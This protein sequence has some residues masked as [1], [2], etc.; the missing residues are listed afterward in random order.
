[1]IS[2]FKV[3]ITGGRGFTGRFLS[4]HLQNVGFEVFVLKSNFLDFE[5]LNREV[6]SISPSYVIHLGALSFAAESNV[7]KLYEVNVVGTT[8]LLDSLCNLTTPLTKIILASSAT[9]YGNLSESYLSENMIPKPV[10]HYG[11]SKLSMEFMASNYIEKLNLLITRPFN[12]TGPLQGDRFLIPKIVNAYKSGHEKLELGNLDVAREFN[13]IRDI[14]SIYKELLLTE[15]ENGEVLNICSG[16][17]IKLLDVIE[18]CDKYFNQKM[19]V[20]VNS[21]FVRRNEIK[22]LAGCPDKLNSL[23]GD[24]WSFSYQ[25]TIKFIATS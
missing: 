16:R 5:S 24:K 22:T 10:N 13:D 23:I 2:P 4:Q 11:C 14:C 8:N 20:M 21:E 18:F 9:V 17:A 1:M 15:T 6:H 7:E 12:Y 19:N 3:L 25:D